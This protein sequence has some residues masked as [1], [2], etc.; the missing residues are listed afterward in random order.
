MA[1][2]KLPKPGG[3]CNVCMAPSD[4]REALNHRCNRVVNGRR[5]PGNVKSAVHALWDECD[6]CHATGR[7][8]S[9]SCTGCEGF[10]W[11]LYA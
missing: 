10:G 4:R 7:A 11:R 9:Q 3:V 5:C 6:S 2:T 1:V 8:G